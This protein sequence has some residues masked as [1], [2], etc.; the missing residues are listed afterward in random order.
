M[1]ATATKPSK[2]TRLRALIDHPRTGQA[3]RQAA[4]RMLARIL[5]NQPEQMRQYDDALSVAYGDK[6]AATANLNTTEVAKLIRE[7]IKIARK[8]GTRDG[9]SVDSLAIRNPIGDAP[10]EI[11]FSVR[12]S[13]FAGGSSIDIIIR[14]IP[15]TWGYEMR[16]DDYDGRLRE[17]P[18]GALFTL[19]NDLAE[20]MAR[21]N[22][23]GSDTQ[24]DYWHVR[25]Y[26]NVGAEGG[27]C[28][29]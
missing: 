5:A 20:V 11:K 8:M 27:L 13:Y 18:T 14:N 25:F 16:E 26:A 9:D 6:Y 15:H 7:D 2:I 4:E 12:T 3:E 17:M 21:Y 19:A 1:N 24:H 22:Y 28:L 29:A 23:D 10:A